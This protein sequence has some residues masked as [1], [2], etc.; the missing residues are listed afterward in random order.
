[1]GCDLHRYLCLMGQ[2]SHNCRKA[3]KALDVQA[4]KDYDF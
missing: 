1:M 4:V 2:Y 3:N